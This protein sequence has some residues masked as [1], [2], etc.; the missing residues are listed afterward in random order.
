M[1]PSYALSG[2]RRTKPVRLRLKRIPRELQSNR[3]ACRKL[4]PAILVMQAAQDWATKN[5]PDAIDGAR[6]RLCVPKTL[7]EL[8]P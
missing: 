3:C 7:S 6:D 1:G 8:M 4:N 2:Y 5:A